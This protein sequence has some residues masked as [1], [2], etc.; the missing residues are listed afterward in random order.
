MMNREQQIAERL[1]QMPPKYRATY[2][3]AVEGKSLRACVNS[4][5]LECCGWE[6]AEVGACTDSGC[7]LYAVRPYQDG[8]G[9]GQD[10]QFGGAEGPNEAGG[11]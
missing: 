5:C 9:S 6:R 8:S 7:P 11:E 10:G 3:R 2:R 4:Q 1:R